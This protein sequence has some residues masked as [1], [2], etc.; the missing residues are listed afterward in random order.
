ML[1]V[2]AHASTQ[3]NT[4]ESLWRGLS[5]CHNPQNKETTDLIYATVLHSWHTSTLMLDK[6]CAIF[7]PLTNQRVEEKK[8][9]LFLHTILAFTFKMLHGGCMDGLHSDTNRRQIPSYCTL[10]RTDG[11]SLSGL[12]AFKCVLSHAWARA[13]RPKDNGEPQRTL[14]GLIWGKQPNMIQK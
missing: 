10:T 1:Q 2:H 5:C 9:A 11:I 3:T 6:V 7:H 13:S 12:K 14:S 8:T 4:N